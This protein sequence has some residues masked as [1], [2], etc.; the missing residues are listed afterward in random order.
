M[1]PG[2]NE[3][4]RLWFVDNVRIFL[5]VLVIAHHAG[6]PYEPTG[7]MWLVSNSEQADILGAFFATNAAFFMGLFFL[8]SGYFVPGAY[9]R[10]GVK[11]FLQERFLRLGVPIL[12]FA[13]LVFPPVFYLSEPREESFGQF[14]IQVYLRQPQ[15]QAGHLWFLMHLLVYTVCYALWCGVIRHSAK[16]ASQRKRAFPGHGLILLYLI[17]LSG[18]TFLTRIYY[19]IDTWEDVLRIPTEIAHLPQ[20]LSLFAIGIVAYQHDWFR[21]LPRQQGL[22]WLGIGL[23]AV[24]LRYVYTLSGESWFPT[25]IVAS[26]GWN[27]RSLLWSFWE[28][29]ICIGLC[30]GILTLF[31]EY[32][33]RRGKWERL[34]SVNAYT[35]YLIHV[36]PVIALQIGFAPLPISP[37][38]KFFGVTLLGVPLCF[39]LSH[40]L[41][42]LP[43]ANTIL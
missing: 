13:L 14:L 34:L 26:G 24:L 12:F 1:E 21:K 30:I 25:R 41:R 33:N 37:L 42:K 32:F 15:M 36:L 17:L 2:Q 10:K 39:L 31:R 11:V 38:L 6:Q 7:G 22:I 40:Y 29:T 3:P 35:V 16:L 5:T 43:L 19:P 20:Y 23:G 18:V 28:T 8:I 9:A 27:W 4:L